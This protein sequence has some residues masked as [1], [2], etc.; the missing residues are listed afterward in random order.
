MKQL[1]SSDR[2]CTHIAPSLQ[3]ITKNCDIWYLNWR[4]LFSIMM[5]IHSSR[6]INRCKK[7]STSPNRDTA[8]SSGMENCCDE[9]KN[10][11]IERSSPGSWNPE[12]RWC[13]AHI[14]RRGALSAIYARN[15]AH[16]G[17][18]WRSA[19]HPG[20][21]AVALSQGTNRSVG[22]GTGRVKR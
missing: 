15:R 9:S 12:S 20:G 18:A 1:L 7:S 4:G 8:A 10:P 16:H 6:H 21:P 22:T 14:R 3:N 11:I 13:I 2:Y 17:A 5:T 19:G